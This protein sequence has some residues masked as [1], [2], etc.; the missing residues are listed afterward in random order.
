MQFGSRSGLLV[1]ASCVS[2]AL[3]M[4][5]DQHFY[6]R[7]VAY[8]EELFAQAVDA[9]NLADEYHRLVPKMRGGNRG[10]QQ[11]HGVR[12]QGR[13]QHGMSPTPLHVCTVAKPLCSSL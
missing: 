11:S 1:L 13:P 5:Q 12:G 6:A 7:E 8:E 4:P 9:H 10:I 2:F 3:A